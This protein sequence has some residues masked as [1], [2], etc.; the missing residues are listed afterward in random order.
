MDEDGKSPWM[1]R[2]RGIAIIPQESADIQTIGGDADIQNAY[3]PELDITYFL[4]EELSLELILAT[5]PH[6]IK[7]KNT[8]LGDVDLGDAWLLPPT[9][10]L[11]YHFD[12]GD[13]KP[14]VGAG[15][16]YTIFY[17]DEAPQGYDVDYEDGFGWA[18]Q[19]GVDFWHHGPWFANIDL[20]KIFIN[21]DATV[22]AGGTY[23]DADVDIDPWVVG[24][25]IGFRL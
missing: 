16:N 13:I 25:G 15:V 19:V 9:L 3:V 6:D 24:I 20:K 1:F 8:A 10:L 7:A 5:A 21:T 17:G 4:T 23:L 12:L 22:R 2:L 11:Q 18:L 14:Y